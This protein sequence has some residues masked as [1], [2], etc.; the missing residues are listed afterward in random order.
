MKKFGKVVVKLR[1]PI[2]VLSFLLL[3]PSVIG[4][5]NTRV[6]YDILYYLP[7]DIDTMQGQDI[8]LDDF[9]KGAYAMVVV[10]GMNKSNVSKLVK[11]VEGVDHVASVISYSG[12][13]GDDVPSEILPDKFRSYFENEDSGATL[14]AIFFDDTTSSDDTMKAI[15]E[16]RDVTDNQCYI[17]GMSAVV[18]DTKTMAEKETPFYVLV[19][20]V[21]VCIVLA[22]FMDSFLVPVFFMLSIGM[23][24][25]YNLGSNYFLGEVSYITKALA[26]V[27]QLGVTLDYSIFLWHSYKEA[28]EETPDDHHEAMAVAIGNTLTSVVGSSITT[29]AGFIALCFMSFTLGLDLGVVMAKGVV[30]GVIGCVTILPS[31]ILTFDKALEKTM[32]REIMP[33]FDKPARWIV[34]HSWIFLIIFVLLLGPAIY[35]YNNTKVYYDLSDTLPE[36]LNCSQANKMLAENFDGTNS[37]YMILAD[38]NLSAEDSNAMMNEV[39]DLDGIS[40]ALSIDSALGGEIPTE[41]LP[42]SLVSELKGD[43][44]QIMMVSTNYTIASDEIND[45]INKV[46]AIAKKYD[47]KSMVIGE[48]PCT[49]DLITIT[50]KDFKTVSAVSIVA[51]FFIIFFVLKSISLPVILVAAIEFAIFVNMGIPYYTGTTIPFISSVVIGTI[52]LGAT[53]DYAILMTTRYKRERAA[54]NSKKEAISIALGTSIPSII[55]SALGFF[56]ATFGVGMIASVDMIA[57]LCTLMARGAIISMFVVIFVLPS[58][59]VLLDKVIIHT[60]LGFKPKKNSQN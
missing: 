1:I 15:Q 14:F 35:G 56:A 25:V 49:K 41:M 19:A 51:I 33:N 52:Q 12:V 6:N 39:N 16:V 24:I 34:N 7:N 9:G 11:K 18:T 22:I 30:L 47:A 46:D 60:S 23:A 8:L 5:F 54:G 40:F 43:E 31:L 26:A 38:S 36:K 37:I 44:Y 10:D 55:V 3:I 21:L 50:D 20:V 59:F 48:A 13:V 45:Q 27:L 17:A 42:D 53:V 58:L 2:L 32:H 29:V 28:K 4:Y 57:S